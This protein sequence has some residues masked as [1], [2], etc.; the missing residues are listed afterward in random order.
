MNPNQVHDEAQRIS[1]VVSLQFIPETRRTAQPS[2]ILPPWQSDPYNKR[3]DSKTLQEE[4]KASE[5]P[6]YIRKQKEVMQPM[7]YPRGESSLF[8]QIGENQEHQQSS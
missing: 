4:P 3:R 6:G 1:Q 2:K 5:S 7:E 8:R